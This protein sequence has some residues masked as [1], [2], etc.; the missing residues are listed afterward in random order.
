MRFK[1]LTEPTIGAAMEVH[2]HLGPGLLESVYEECLCHEFT[3]RKIPFQRQ[4][5]SRVHYKGL[6]LPSGY[7][8][9]LLLFDTVVVEL[10]AVESLLPVHK[11][12]TLRY[13]RLGNWPVGLPINFNETVLSS[14]IRRV[15][16]DP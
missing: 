6:H 5:Q 1:E 16:F 9:D 12:Q 7:R 3:T 4:V 13:F 11:A 10:K 8:L 2:R 14:G 15:V